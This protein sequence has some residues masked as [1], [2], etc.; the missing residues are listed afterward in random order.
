VKTFLRHSV[1]SKAAHLYRKLHNDEKVVDDDDGVTIAYSSCGCVRL[2]L[3]A[4]IWL[5]LLTV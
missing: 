4:C 2:C 5:C 3:Q 1:V